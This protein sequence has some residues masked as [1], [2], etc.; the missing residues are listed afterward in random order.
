MKKTFKYYFAIWA[1]LLVLFN[2]VAFMVGGIENSEKYTSGFW[3]GYAFI[4]LVFLAQLACA[5]VAFNAKNLQK[6]FY[7]YS[8]ISI[9]YSAL[10][11]MFVVGGLCMAISG[12]PYWIGVVACVI[13]LAVNAIAVVK[14]S[15]AVDAVAAVDEKIKVQTFFIKSLTVDAESLM[16]RAK[17]EAVKAECKKV[18][19][20]ARY[21][22]PMSSDALSSV[23]SEITLR[24]AK[25]SAAVAEDDAA[26][27]A[28]CANEVVI[29]IG[30]RNKKCKLLK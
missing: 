14:A 1:I 17:S 29:L 2:V 24:F 4:T 3:I 5:K 23:E 11:T 9:S 7:N 15:I 18:Y 19:E 6:M 13:V 22:D 8:L 16:A 30:D 20:A 10:I 28:E 27:V 21:S 26:A 25:L 12:L